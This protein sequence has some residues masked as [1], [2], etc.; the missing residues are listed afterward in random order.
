MGAGEAVGSSESAVHVIRGRG[1][2]S[3][4]SGKGN[5]EKWTEEGLQGQ[6]AQARG[7]WEG[8]EGRCKTR[9]RGEK[10][11]ERRE[12]WEDQQANRPRQLSI[13]P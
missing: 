1:E 11:R 8:G 5:G 6:L 7:A 9:V 3:M 12:D 13:W 2:E 4:A 10:W